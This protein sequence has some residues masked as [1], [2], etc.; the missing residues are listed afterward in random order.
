MA[1]KIQI[2]VLPLSQMFSG[3]KC[4]MYTGERC[5]TVYM[6]EDDYRNL[7][8]DGFFIRSSDTTDSS[9]VINT[10]RTFKEHLPTP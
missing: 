2:D 1:H 8:N 10:T 7:V 4:N 3:V 5:V 6:S 9:G